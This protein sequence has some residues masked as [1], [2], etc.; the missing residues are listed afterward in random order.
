MKYAPANGKC[1]AAFAYFRN[2]VY[3]IFRTD[4][5]E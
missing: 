4:M 3:F 5:T 2:K 1:K